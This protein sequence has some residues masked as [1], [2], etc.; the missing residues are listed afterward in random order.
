MCLEE[1][2]ENTEHLFAFTVNIIEAIDVINQSKKL[3]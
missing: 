2:S 1:I 3:D